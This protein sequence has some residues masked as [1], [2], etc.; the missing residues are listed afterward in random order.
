[1][2]RHSLGSVAPP[3]FV[4][5]ADAG[6]QLAGLLLGL[7]GPQTIV[8]GLPRGG[9]VV[10]AEVAAALEVPLDVILVRKL[11]L[12]VHPELAMGAIG[13]GGVRVLNP[14]V[15]THAGVSDAEVE[16]VAR[17]ERLE[18]ER[19]ATEYRGGRPPRD[20][21]AH[22]VVVVDDGIATGATARAA[23]AVARAQGAARVVLAVPVAPSGWTDELRGA[24]DEFV[25]VHAP[26]RFGG[27]GEFYSDFR[28]TTDGEVIAA[29]S[30]A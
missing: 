14:D 5:R 2:A 1:V 18:L 3:V 29:L 30:R 23:C 26:R 11:G 21:H 10:A 25:A 22:T 7:R 4:D 16:A 13:E 12:P 20:L 19:R 6:R 8:V 15:V 9:V 27:V 28:Q 24:A 17:R